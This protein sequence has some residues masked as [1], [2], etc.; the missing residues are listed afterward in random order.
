MYFAIIGDIVGSRKLKDRRE[1]QQR[2][3]KALNAINDH[4]TGDMASKFTI[5]LGDEFQGLLKD[6]CNILE[7][8]DLIRFQVYPIELRFGVGIGEM[9]TEIIEEKS[10]GSDGPAY[11]AAREAI[12]Y[13]HNSND[14]GVSKICFRIG[15]EDESN[16]LSHIMDSVNKTLN[17]CDRME[18]KWTDTQFS[19]VRELILKYR[20]SEVPQKTIAADQKLTPQAINVKMK[21]TGIAAYI[22]AR[23]SIENLLKAMCKE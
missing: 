5:T 4:Y 6:P 17:L 1:A 8:V 3:K 7:I 16:L 9:Q 14:Y 18:N 11:W 22:A 15:D 23:I 12:Q 20:Y 19:F 13:I 10:L 2:L 21:T